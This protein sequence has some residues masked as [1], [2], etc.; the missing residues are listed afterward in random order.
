MD[1]TFCHAAFSR[2]TSS[3][4]IYRVRR[5]KRWNNGNRASITMLACLMW[6]P[7]LFGYLDP[8][9]G[10]IYNDLARHKHFE[11]L[12][13]ERTKQRD[14]RIAKPLTNLMQE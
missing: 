14:R 5:A 13:S 10:R 12:E 6:T 3:I 11:E 1:A 4:L 7:R 8:E 9:E 2:A